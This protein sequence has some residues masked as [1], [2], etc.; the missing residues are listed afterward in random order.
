MQ[1]FFPFS[2]TKQLPSKPKRGR[3][4]LRLAASVLLCSSS[5]SG[6]ASFF[7]SE[8]AQAAP[9]RRDWCGTIWSTE[10]LNG[11]LGWINP[12]TGVTTL[13]TGP[14]SQI[15]SIP[16]G[17]TGTSVAALAI[18]KISGT[19]FMFDRNGTTGRLYK[20][21]FGV[22]TAWQPLTV[23]GLIGLSGTQT[24]PGASSNL[25]KMSV[26]DNTLFIGES[27]AV[28]IYAVPLDSNGNVIGGATAQTYT[29]VGDPVG[30]PPHRS[31]RT[32]EPLGT[33]VMN[34]GDITTDE[35]G[36]V[37]NITYNVIVT[38]VSPQVISTT[39]AYFYKQD[40]VARTWIYQ[41][42]TAV[43]A[44]F[45]GAAFYKGDLFAK[46]GNQ[47]KRVDLTRVAIGYT[48]W[49]NP[50]VNVGPTS[51]T[52]SSDLAACGTPVLTVVKARQI[53]EDAALTILATDQSKVRTGKYIKYT[54]T[55]TNIGDEWALVTKIT[56]NLPAG[57]IY[58]PNSATLNGNNVALVTY[59]TDGGIA[60]KSAGAPAGIIRYAPDP[61]TATLTFGVQ[62][63]ATDGA[64]RNQATTTY[65]DSSDLPSEPPD[66]NANPPVN[67][68]TDGPPLPLS[69]DYGDAPDAAAG[70]GTGN[71]QTTSTDNGPSHAL[72]SGIQLGVNIDDDSGTL[73]NINADADDTTNTPNDEDGVKI[74]AST[75][76]NQTLS[77]GT[78]TTL[79]IA[80]QGDGKL[81]AWIDW[82]RDGDFLDAGEQI[83]TDVSPTSN[84]ISLPITVPATATIGR[85]YAR[86]RYS[87]QTGLAPTG[88]ALDGE[89]E[90]YALTIVEGSKIPKLILLKRITAING[91]TT[92]N[93]NDNT[94]LNQFVDGSGTD[95]NNPNWATPSTYLIGAID[96]GLVNSQDEVEYTIYFLNTEADAR[97]VKLCDTVPD[98]QTFVPTAYNSASPRPLDTESLG[99]D[100]GIAL[101]FSST[102]LPTSPTVYL[103]NLQDTATGDRGR[104]YPAGDLDTPATCKKFDTS[105]NV[106]ATG[107]A[108]NTN[109]AVVVDIVKGTDVIPPATGAGTPSNSYGFIRF[110][111][112]LNP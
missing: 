61:N 8:P 11:A 18:H 38:Q 3:S 110:R 40:P 49:N 42:Q 107:V 98:N 43:N 48:G 20:F 14:T 74:G 76:Q 106:T 81:N 24:I 21:K 96:G 10:N 62:V 102:S 60:I 68:A 54:I 51:A 58:V 80:T 88:N 79:D 95:D 99:T 19:M 93:P 72:V 13:G 53:Y 111:A 75:L 108:A 70:T 82:N 27:N 32:G 66:C 69:V 41:G 50:L 103:T 101:G 55:T 1:S 9:T 63:T 45:A 30:T 67:C 105:G 39:K 29:F 36:D 112:K 109:G 92:R 4:Y 16:G 5:F 90:D 104:F 34:G 33:E 78:N 87:T 100:T 65:I 23:S 31:L 71:Y 2:L 7:F 56:D 97:N 22:D 83:A 35:Y 25:N 77:Q 46:A 37:Y 59:P 57:T 26:D 73:Q 6:L 94:P 84:A 52:S 28:A 85:T 12:N 91:N 17:V 44:Q 86:F 15:P 64:I 47:L 89:V